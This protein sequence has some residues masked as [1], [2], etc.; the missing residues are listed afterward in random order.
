MSLSTF[1]YTVTVCVVVCVRAG[2]SAELWRFSTSTRVWERVDITA[3]N[4][5]GPSARSYHV[6]TS[7]GLDL[8]VHGGQTNPGEGDACATHV[9]LLLLPRLRQRAM[10]DCV[11]CGVCLAH[12]L[13]AICRVLRRAESVSLCT[14]SD[15]VCCGVCTSHDLRAICRVLHRAVAVLH[16]HVC[17]GASRHHSGQ[18]CWPQRKRKSRHD[19]RGAGPVGAWWME[20]DGFR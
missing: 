3:A 19:L 1:S 12:D 5:A 16:I 14:L 7:V 6:M 8:W 10:S 9:T 11:C 20:M 2:N 18:R 13:R 4:G 15:C 17:V